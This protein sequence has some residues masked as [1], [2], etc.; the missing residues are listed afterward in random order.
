VLADRS[1]E[2]AD[3]ASLSARTNHQ[4]IGSIGEI[5]QHLG[6]AAPANFAAYNHSWILTEGL[7]DCG[8]QGCTCLLLR[9]E[10]GCPADVTVRSRDDERRPN[11]HNGQL[12]AV[13]SRL[14]SRPLQGRPAVVGS[15]DATTTRVQSPMVFPFLDCL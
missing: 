4:R 10:L 13:C 11:R 1:K 5:D 15:I 6:R 8:L 12:G 7:I 9:V 14:F 2:Q 3:K